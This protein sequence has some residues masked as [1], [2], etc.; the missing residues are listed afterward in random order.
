MFF[1]TAAA[2]IIGIFS[3]L[4]PQTPK[5]APRHKTILPF[6]T[7]ITHS[8]APFLQIPLQAPILLACSSDVMTKNSFRQPNQETCCMCRIAYPVSATAGGKC[9]CKRE[10]LELC[11]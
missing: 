2:L 1:K 7:P 10:K 5:L 4:N 6:F 9:T 3:N 11:C 8:L